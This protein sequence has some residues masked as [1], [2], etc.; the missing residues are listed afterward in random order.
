MFRGRSDWSGWYMH[1]IRAGGFPSD[2]NAIR[3]FKIVRAFPL[4]VLSA[5]C[6]FGC[7]RNAQEDL[8]FSAILTHRRKAS[9]VL[10]HVLIVPW[11]RDHVQRQ[12]A[13]WSPRRIA[14]R[15]LTRDGSPSG[16]TSSGISVSIAAAVIRRC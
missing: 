1:K 7:V 9:D 15:R 6:V 12:E 3:S 4:R 14:S 16:N 2:V 11:R 5:E 10:C 13:I 8:E